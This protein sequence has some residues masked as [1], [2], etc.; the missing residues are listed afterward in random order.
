MS[1]D[2]SSDGPRSPSFAAQLKPS[3]L[4]ALEALAAGQGV[5]EAADAAGV[6]R[7]TIW[8]WTTQP[9]HADFQAALNRRKQQL[10]DAIDQRLMRVAE[11]A[12]D[13]LYLT[14]GEADG[15][16][17]LTVLREMDLLSRT[18]QPIGPTDPNAIRAHAKQEAQRERRRTTNQLSMEALEALFDQQDR[19][20]WAAALD[21]LEPVQDDPPEPSSGPRPQSSETDAHSADSVDPEPDTGGDD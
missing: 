2:P 7:S 17:A 15:E 3:Q 18:H 12:V 9:Q 4:H 6:K 21:I 13:A 16:L 11:A 1:A 14:L 8:R 10:I 20:M 5:Q 19:H